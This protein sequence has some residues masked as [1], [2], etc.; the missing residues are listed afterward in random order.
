MQK[1]NKEQVIRPVAELLAWISG[2]EAKGIVL[3]QRPENYIIKIKEE[4]KMFKRAKRWLVIS[5]IFSVVA[6]SAAFAALPNMY[7]KNYGT[8]KTGDICTMEAKGDGNSA[9]TI[10]KNTT[11]SKR[12]YS[13]YVNRRFAGSNEVIDSDV[14][15]RVV[16]ASDTVKASVARYPKKENREHYHKAMGW[17]CSMQPS[18]AGYTNF[19]VDTLTYTIKQTK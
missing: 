8:T 17:N 5:M 14:D 16:D 1:S 19:L 4:M 12:Y 7:G 11:N 6:G 13:A 18:G 10:V 9:V 2:E 15:E 3:Y